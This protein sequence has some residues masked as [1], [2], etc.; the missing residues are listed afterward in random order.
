MQLADV[1]CA[2]HL[3]TLL[4]QRYE[5]FSELLLSHLQRIYDSPITKDD[6]K[7]GEDLRLFALEQYCSLYL[8]VCRH[9]KVQAWAKT[10]WRGVSMME[11]PS[12]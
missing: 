3:C 12:I 4:H 10:Y 2:I 11:N 6:E 5:E 8:V 7:V 1:S 9:L